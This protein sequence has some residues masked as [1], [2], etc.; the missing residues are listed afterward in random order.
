MLGSIRYI[1]TVLLVATVAISYHPMFFDLNG[2]FVSSISAFIALLMISIVATM[3]PDTRLI[4]KSKVLRIY[5]ICLLCIFTWLCLLTG[6]GTNISMNEIRSLLISFVCLCIGYIGNFSDTQ[7]NILACVYLVCVLIAG[8]LQITTNIGSF[9]IE[10]TYLV[11][12]KNA[13]GPMIACAILVG[14]HYVLK[15][16]N[17]II[18]L[19]MAALVLVGVV[20]ILTIRARLATLA[21]FAVII[22]MLILYIH[23]QKSK[24][25]VLSIL[26]VVVCVCLVCLFNETVS[27]YVIKSFTQNREDNMLSSRGDGYGQALQVLSESPLWGNLF[28]NRDIEWVHNYL[29]L[30]LSS[31]GV[32]GC[33]PWVC[34]YLYL[35]Y[36]IF[37][38]LWKVDI[39]NIQH[40]GLTL[41]LVPFIV[42]LG[43]PMAPYGPGTAVFVPFLLYGATLNKINNEKLQLN[44]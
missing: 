22:F 21:C 7:I 15:P 9:E 37:I 5:F 1:L 44:V 13:L 30:K 26:F 16:G 33:I 36:T 11:Q 23:R 28:I 39:T 12:A 14:L 19:L 31:F 8:Y 42:S 24:V 29:L 27:D 4:F 25:G 43:E 35:S 3:L 20:E 38:L 10:D 6:L 18:R 17:L 2:E 40:L 34:L 41:I 32:F